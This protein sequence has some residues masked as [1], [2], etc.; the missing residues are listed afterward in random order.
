MA[1]RYYDEAFLN[2]IKA[3]VKDEKLTITGPD[4]TRRLFE[5][6]ADMS[7]DAPIP[8]PLITLTR[9]RDIDIS[10]TNK[11]PLTFDGMPMKGYKQDVQILDAIPI[12]LRYQINI[13]TRYAKEAD[14]YVRNFVFNLVNYNTLDIVIPY[15]NLNFTHRSKISLDSPISDTSDI[16]ERLIAGQFTRYTISVTIDDAYLFS[17]PIRKTWAID[18]ETEPRLKDQNVNN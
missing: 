11:R 18:V 13:F 9:N 8:L 14:E 6:R 12:V 1:V 16:P 17:A 5:Y 2:K 4:E 15:N 10:V 3:W 7:N